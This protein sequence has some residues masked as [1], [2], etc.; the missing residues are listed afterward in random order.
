M[1]IEQL[2]RLND[3]ITRVLDIQDATTPAMNAKLVSPEYAFS[4]GLWP[5][6][7]PYAVSFVEVE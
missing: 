3:G 7:V 2:R 4:V 1:R 6:R 5:K